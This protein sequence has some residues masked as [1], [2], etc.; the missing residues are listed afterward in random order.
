MLLSFHWKYIESMSTEVSKWKFWWCFTIYLHLKDETWHLIL[1]QSSLD[2]I[3]NFTCWWFWV[4]HPRLAQ[5][6]LRCYSKGLTFYGEPFTSRLHYSP[7]LS[8]AN[9]TLQKLQN[10]QHSVWN[11]SVDCFKDFVSNKKKMT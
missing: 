10:T 4:R 1:F 7:W 8:G 6:K 5:C 2:I 11:S 3:T 9:E